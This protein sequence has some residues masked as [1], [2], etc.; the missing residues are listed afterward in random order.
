LCS[1]QLFHEVIENHAMHKAS[2]AAADERR[3]RAG[4]CRPEERR[5]G[6]PPSGELAANSACLVCAVMASNLNVCTCDNQR[7]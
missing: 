7:S 3:D 6:G 2:R 4:S 5:T 1:L